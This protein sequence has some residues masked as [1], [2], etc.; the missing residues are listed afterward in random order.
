MKTNNSFLFIFLAITHFTFGQNL[1]SKEMNGQVF[2][3]SSSVDGVTVVNNA[4]QLTTITDSNGLFS[5]VI[6][7]GD[8]LVFSAINL[9]GYK[10][11]ITSSDLALNFLPIK[12]KAKSIEL[13]EVVINESNISAESLGIIPYGQ[14]KY[15]AA[16]R[17][18]YTANS[19][20]IDA[21][22]NA[23]SGRS[24]MLKKEI[25]VEKKERMLYK[26]EGLFEEDYYTQRLKIP[27]DHIKGFQYY[28]IENPEF[29]RTLESKNKS[30]SM[31]LIT[32]LAQEYLKIIENED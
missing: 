7:E 31:F 27:A 26:I 9:E 17:K 12:M 30:M 10:K 24:K 6:R 20:P 25:I 5:I 11:R 29:M 21:L 16:E 15:T 32:Q 18:L 4:T 3:D 22:L 1:L 8:V 19:T 13:K 23:M 14:K 2:A 28:C